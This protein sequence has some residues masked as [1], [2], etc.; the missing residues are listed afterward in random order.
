MYPKLE[1]S[2]FFFQGTRA[3]ERR[4]KSYISSRKRQ[5][6][7]KGMKGYGNG[8]WRAI[9]GPS[10]TNIHNPGRIEALW[11]HVNSLRPVF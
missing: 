2:Y 8:V 1:R 3:V 9:G 6:G 4:L 7:I 5:N 11:S 10:S